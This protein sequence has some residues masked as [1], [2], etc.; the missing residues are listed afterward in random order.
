MPIPAPEMQR[1]LDTRVDGRTKGF[2][3]D[4]DT[5]VG[6]LGAH[7]WNVLAGDLPTPVLV[8]AESALANNL[9]VMADW[10]TEHGVWLAPHGKTTM[11]PQIVD[12]QFAHGAWAVTAADTVQARIFAEHGADRIVVANQVVDPA[13]LRWLASTVTDGPE[14]YVL[15][16]SA[17]GVGLLESA[18]GG[19]EGRLRVLL[20]LGCDGGRS[21]VR[22]A[23][24]AAAVAAA[25]AGADH[26]VLAGVEAFEGVVDGGDPA[27]T[28]DGVDALVRRLADEAHRL[29]D[30]GAFGDVDEVV[31]T[32]GG[33][34]WFDR[35]ASLVTALD[36]PIATRVVLRSG[37]YVAHDDGRNHE[38]SPLDGRGDGRHGLRPALSVFAH[39]LSR[40]EAGLAVLGMG[41]R[42]VPYDVGP[43][44]PSTVHT[45]AGPRPLQDVRITR[46]FD[47]HAVASLG[48]G[49]E[50]AVGDLV[51]S[52]IDHPCTAFDRWRVIPVVDDDLTVTSGVVTFF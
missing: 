44:L 18:L 6:A 33:S 35:V 12:R 9:A 22:T 38:L 29:H 31:V 47:Q 24:E 11:A 13:G 49:S 34:S 8:L 20:E 50:L 7:G 39:V 15:V 16:D 43:P 45:P 48:P 25:V 28:R 46:M 5:T 32:A 26:L 36:L 30:T 51:A 41:K 14:V 10:C 23:Q 21:G 3:A 17:T 52:G 37:G 4:A 40:P 2:P 42:D 1:I 19:V 27:A